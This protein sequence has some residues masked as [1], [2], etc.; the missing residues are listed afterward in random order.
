MRVGKAKVLSKKA[1]RSQDIH[2]Y[3]QGMDKDKAIHHYLDEHPTLPTALPSCHPG[4]AAVCPP[5]EALRHME[6]ERVRALW[7]YIWF[8]YYSLREGLGG[9]WQGRSGVVEE[10]GFY[11]WMS[12]CG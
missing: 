3:K 6:S 9:G 11:P 7:S 1:R 5:I 12:E 10:E 4:P 2:L 8:S